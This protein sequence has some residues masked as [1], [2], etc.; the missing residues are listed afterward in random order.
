MLETKYLQ[1]AQT[2][3]GRKFEDLWAGPYTAAEVVS[4]NAVRLAGFPSHWK[5]HPVVNVPRVR[6][7]VEGEDVFPGRPRR[8]REAEVETEPL[9]FTRVT[10]FLA[11]RRSP[12]DRR[13]RQVLVEWE[14]FED[15]WGDETEMRSDCLEAF[16]IWPCKVE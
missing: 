13:V 10:R 3:L 4:R 12:K 7:Y 8:D 1:A 11:R 6:A 14:D 5:V 15:T 2:G 16:G 9:P